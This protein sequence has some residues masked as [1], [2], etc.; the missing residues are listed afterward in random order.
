M[1]QPPRHTWIFFR[2]GGFDQVRLESGADLAALGELDQKLW[3][4]LAC[5]T[6]GLEFDART[7]ALIDSD[8]DG[9]IRAPDI[10]AAARWATANLKN[11]DDLLRGAPTLPL[12]AINDEG[13][14]GRQIIVSAKNILA[15]LGKPDADIITLDDTSDTA[16]I[17]A[18]T[19]FNGSGIVPAESAQDQNTAALIT[20]IIKYLGAV[21]DRSGKPGIDQDT[22]DRF[23]QALHAYADWWAAGEAQP[24][25]MPLGEHTAAAYAALAALRPRI[26]DYFARCRLAAYDSRAALALNRKTEEYAALADRTL[27]AHAEEFA[28]FP[29]AKIEA[30]KPLP[31]RT[32]Y[33]PA[34]AEPL[35]ALRTTVITPLYGADKAT[36]SAAEWEDIKSR[37]APYQDW[38]AKK[39]GAVVEPLGIAR[40]RELIAGDGRERVAALIAEDRALEPAMNAIVAVERLIRYHRDLYVLLNNFVNFRD[41]YSRTHKA[42]FQAGTLYLDGRA[43]ELCVRVDDPARH[44][45]LA[46]QSNAYLV[47]LDCT[48]HGK[49][50][51]LGIVAAVTNGDADQLMVGRNGVFYDRQGQDWDA[52]VVKI[53]ENPIGL[54]QA[55]WAPYKRMARMIGEQIEKMA[56]A[57]DK[58][59]SSKAAAGI[60]S[61]TAQSAAATLRRRAICRHLCRHRSCQR[62][63]RHGARGGDHRLS[64]AGVVADTARL[65][66][67]PA[68]H[69]RTCG[70]AGLAQAAPPQPRPHPRRQRL[71]GQYPRQDQHP[72]RPY[73]DRARQTAAG[74][75]ALVRRSVCGSAA[76]PLVVSGAVLHRRRSGGLLFTEGE[77]VA[78]S[79]ARGRTSTSWACKGEIA[80]IRCTC[81]LS[82]ANQH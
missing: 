36:L 12:A 75:A 2:V 72:V 11:P 21:T 3:T 57:K 8:N 22:L 18:Q 76:R 56:A 62:R 39:G 68:A 81:T 50:D 69:L 54:R 77:N 47:Y 45:V 64:I 5:P 38:Q 7:L 65:L 4:A 30:D 66:R 70:G 37:F 80:A 63:A 20:D 42:V 13:D 46:A 27:S 40:V 41:F 74:R 71:G 1:Q 48:R 25:V 10:I 58:V 44:A 19:R 60:H 53:I 32:G 52:T 6:K 82:I 59:V 16:K 35:A 17:F 61:A 33:N 28:E 24:G 26:D 29:L 73:P 55:A 67:H 23:F 14:E 15:N 78:R 9:R 31:L 34:W 43:C 49:A 51:K 79:G